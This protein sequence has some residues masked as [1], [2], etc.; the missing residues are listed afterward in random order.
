MDIIWNPKTIE[1]RSME[2]IETYL[3][4]YDFPPAE[5]AVVKRVVHTSGDPALIDAIRL[6]SSA[7]QTGI[8]ALRQG[9]AI[10]TDVNMLLAG[11]N[12]PKVAAL[13]GTVCCAIA[14][15][16]V[17]AAALEW[18]ITRAA[19]EMRLWGSRLNDAVVAIGNAPTALFELIDL[20]EKGIARPALVIATPVGF[21][22]AA[23]AKELL[24]EKKLVP[25]MTLLGTRGGS[26]LAAAMVN[27]LLYFEGEI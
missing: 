18:Q 13:G 14:A 3:Q 1:T 25:Y 7:C 24:H 21:V 16:E 15:A 27:A 20:I 22:G 6:H 9:A 12:K 10:Y 2:I 19:A 26:P 11:I 5:K 4:P 23:E 8:K 17:Q